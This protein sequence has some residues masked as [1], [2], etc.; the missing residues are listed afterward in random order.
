MSFP[1]FQYICSM[2]TELITSIVSSGVIVGVV[3]AAVSWRRKKAEGK[4]SD[5]EAQRKGLD[6]VSEY[7]ERIKSL[8]GE[9]ARRIDR[10]GAKMD[11]V[12][13]DVG[14]LRRDIN[15]ITDYLNGGLRDWKKHKYNIQD[16][17]R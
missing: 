3:E 7:Y 9:Q 15:D 14:S 16:L 4:M 13:D 6:L 2:V 17:D 12:I 1:F 8:D 5:Y 10:I 11:T